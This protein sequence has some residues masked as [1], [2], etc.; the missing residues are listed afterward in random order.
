MGVLWRRAKKCED[1]EATLQRG[2][3]VKGSRETWMQLSEDIG[4]GGS[5]SQV[6]RY[7]RERERAIALGH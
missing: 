3:A 6:G 4:A 5:V 7:L 2:F 1:V